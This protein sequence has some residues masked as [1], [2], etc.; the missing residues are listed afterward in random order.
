[1]FKIESNHVEMVGNDKYIVYLTKYVFFFL[2]DIE[3]R[4]ELWVFFL[5]EI[6]SYICFLFFPL[7]SICMLLLDFSKDVYAIEIVKR[8]PKILLNR[9][10]I[11]YGLYKDYMKIKCFFFFFALNNCFKAR[12]SQT[13][14]VQ[15]SDL[16][17]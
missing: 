13:I 11:V 9:S 15:V 8:V 10:R 5:F 4:T 6:F 17:Q 7:K 3:M 14:S 16:E 1:M 12:L 2:I